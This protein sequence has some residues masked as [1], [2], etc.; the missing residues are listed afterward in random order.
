MPIQ[1]N[2]VGVS[3][4]ALAM[5]AANAVGA[6]KNNGTGAVSWADDITHATEWNNKAMPANVHG[7]LHNDGAGALSWELPAP[8]ALGSW[9]SI[10]F[11]TAYQAATDGFAL[12][13]MSWTSSQSGGA[14]G[15]TDNQANPTTL[16]VQ[17]STN[18]SASNMHG[19]I[20]LPVKKNDY[21]KIVWAGGTPTKAAFWIPVA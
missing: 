11:D 5:P 4:G 7:M 6:L 19:G 2:F 20:C 18:A 12:C 17:G 10:N 1:Q 3:G 8:T 9:S 21:Y 13:Y 14:S 15:Y 16:R